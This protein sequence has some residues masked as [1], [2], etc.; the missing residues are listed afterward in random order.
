MDNLPIVPI[1]DMELIENEYADQH[2]NIWSALKLIEH[3][4]KYKSFD[5]PL[6]GID[7]SR[8]AW[9]IENIDDFIHHMNRVKN[10]NLDHP[11]IL[12]NRGVIADGLHRIVKAILKGEKTI[13]AIRLDD[14]PLKDRQEEG[15]DV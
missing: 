12:D 4:K 2:G 9:G 8:I 15:S 7:L 11:I 5:L 10:T 3:S 14:M 1:D 13:K 6:A